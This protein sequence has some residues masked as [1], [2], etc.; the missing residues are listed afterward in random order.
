LAIETEKPITVQYDGVPVGDYLADI[1]VEA[2][3]ILELKANQTLAPANE[4]Q[5]VNYLT[6]TGLEVGLL[7]NFG[8][9]SLQFK[10]KNRLYQPKQPAKDFTL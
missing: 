9:E 8:A 4:L 5:L 6:A 3:V 7:L 10:R 2:A 1:L